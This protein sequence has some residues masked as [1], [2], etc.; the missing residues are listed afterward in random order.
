M[1]SEEDS[2][3]PIY[4][5]SGNGQ[6]ERMNGIIWKTISLRCKDLSIPIDRWESQLP[7]ALSNIRSLVSTSTGDTPPTK[8]S[9]GGNGG[10]R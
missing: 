2:H 9:L 8:D 10:P 5:P 1:G 6:C 7:F 3:F 4:L